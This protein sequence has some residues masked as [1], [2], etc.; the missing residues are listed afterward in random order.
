MRPLVLSV[1]PRTKQK[2]ENEQG[3]KNLYLHQPRS[4]LGALGRV[5]DGYELRYWSDR[6][7]DERGKS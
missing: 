4:W 6:N 5:W 3:P 1:E 2:H 7:A